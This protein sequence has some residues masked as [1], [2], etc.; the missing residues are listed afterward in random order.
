MNRKAC[1]WSSVACTYLRHGLIDIFERLHGGFNINSCCA[2]QGDPS[3]APPT[4]INCFA[5]R[6]RERLRSAFG[7]E[8][9]VGTGTGTGIEEGGT[10][11]GGAMALLQTTGEE[12]AQITNAG[13][14]PAAGDESFY[15]TCSAAD[16][17]NADRQLLDF[18]LTPMFQRQRRRRGWL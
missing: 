18:R 8:C 4:S 7:V 2:A 6:M 14:V 16:R 3:N 12:S 11:R 10:E 15:R 17:I 5:Y 13:V 9:F 1:G